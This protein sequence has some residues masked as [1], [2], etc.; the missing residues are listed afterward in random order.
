MRGIEDFTAMLA[1]TTE[2][3]RSSLLVQ[4]WQ[5]SL[6]PAG[7]SHLRFRKKP[8][9]TFKYSNLKEMG[10]NPASDLKRAP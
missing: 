6:D 5:S 4:G 2:G 9:T 8:L 7:S 10:L 1:S 3:S